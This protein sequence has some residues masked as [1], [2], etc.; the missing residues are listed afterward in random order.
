VSFQNRS[1]PKSALIVFVDPG[2]DT[3]CWLPLAQTHRAA[4]RRIRF[5]SEKVVCRAS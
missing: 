1:L 2:R 4:G 3:H 5:L